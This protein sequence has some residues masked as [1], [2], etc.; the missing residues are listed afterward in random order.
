VGSFQLVYWRRRHNV[1]FEN[2]LKALEE[3]GAATAESGCAGIFDDPKYPDER[4][5]MTIV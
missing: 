2:F 4:Y 1:G 5:L 3:S